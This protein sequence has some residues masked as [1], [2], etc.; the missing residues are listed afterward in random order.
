MR[1]RWAQPNKRKPMTNNQIL[2][3][4]FNKVKRKPLNLLV[5]AFALIGIGGLI[6][7][8]TNLVNGNVS[9]EYFRRIID[10]INKRNCLVV[11]V[12]H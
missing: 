6:G 11:R 2:D 3:S 10:F 8:T 12:N 9:E 4:E 1:G 7:A 5:L